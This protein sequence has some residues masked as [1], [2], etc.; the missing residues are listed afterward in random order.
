T[1]G[2]SVDLDPEL[3]WNYEAGVRG[4]WS[5]GIRAE[6]TFFRMD[7]SNQVVPAS[8]AGGIGATLTN[9]GETL[10]QGAEVSTHFETDR[11]LG[12]RH[13]F[14][15]TIAY[16]WLPIAEFRGVRFSNISGFGQTLITGNR[17]PYAPEHL[18]T[19]HVRYA[20]AKGWSAMLEG[21]HTGRQ[22]GDDLN[23]V[24][25][26]PNGQR[27]LIP[28]NTLWNLTMNQEL[29]SIRATVFVTVKNLFD[30]V[31]IVDR[32]RGIL[33]TIPRLFQTGIQF[34]F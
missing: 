27:G 6:A 3:S 20:H 12:S 21:V 32:A 19:F 4:Q 17:V 25:P 5:S 24:T 8:L 23:T 11:W 31:A 7:Y 30:R 28:S 14:S 13:R 2:G 29:E 34:R 15:G 1:T 26:T 16:T 9:G 10:H 18:A 33:P 22:F